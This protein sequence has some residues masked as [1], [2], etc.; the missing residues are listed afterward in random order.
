MS[1]DKQYAFG[2][3]GLGTMGCNLL[4]NMAD[5]GFAVAGYDKDVK[6]IALLEE[7]GKGKPV[8]GFTDINNFVRSLK[9]PRAIMV[10]VPA[11]KIVDDV[12]ADLTPILD[13]GDII[14]DGGNSHFTDTERRDLDLKNKGLHFFFPAHWDPKL[15]IPRGQVVAAASIVSPKY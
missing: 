12:I 6:K 3:I 2:M 4:L 11:G 8:K 15:R 14:I 9:S 5:H 10:L 1:A 7:E 13:E